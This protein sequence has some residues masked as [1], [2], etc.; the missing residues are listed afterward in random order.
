MRILSE[1]IRRREVAALSAITLLEIALLYSDGSIRSKLSMDEVFSELEASP[2]FR[3]LP[4]TIEACSGNPVSG[5]GGGR[6]G[7]HLQADGFCSYA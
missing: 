3:V 5:P 6:L 7:V 2:V 4:L 1:V